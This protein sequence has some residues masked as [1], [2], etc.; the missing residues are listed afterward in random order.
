M[1]T[2]RG[3]RWYIMVYNLKIYLWQIRMLVYWCVVS[4][5]QLSP[6]DM[7]SVFCGSGVI[8]GI[9]GKQMTP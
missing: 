1:P 5:H 8:S 2:V 9:L 3:F 6:P 7:V 4:E